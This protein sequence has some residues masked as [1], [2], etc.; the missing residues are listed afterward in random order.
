MNIED[1]PVTTAD[2]DL[3]KEC[4]ADIIGN[5]AHQHSVE[6]HSVGAAF[7]YTN[8]KTAGTVN[9]TGDKKFRI[10]AWSGK[11]LERQDPPPDIETRE[12]LILYEDMDREDVYPQRGD[13]IT[14]NATTHEVVNSELVAIAS[15]P[16][17]Y[18]LQVRYQLGTATQ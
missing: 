2:A 8:I 9:H 1:Y 18:H 10:R 6:Y 12:Y 13:K 4:L 5:P 15:T 17:Y 14:D 16:C 3:V 11:S 7:S